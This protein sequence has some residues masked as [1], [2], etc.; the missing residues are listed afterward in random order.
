[1][2]PHEVLQPEAVADQTIPSTDRVSASAGEAVRSPLEARRGL[3]SSLGWSMP[4]VLGGVSLVLHQVRNP[5]PWVLSWPGLIVVALAVTTAFTDSLWRKI[6]NWLTYPAILAGLMIGVLVSCLGSQ[7][8]LGG[9]N[10]SGSLTGFVVCFLCMLFPYQASGGGAGDVKLAATY[11][12]LLGWQVGLSV[13][14]WSYMMAGLGL[15]VAQLMT[16]QPWLLP[17]ALMR[18]VGST[19]MPQAVAAPSENQKK[20]LSRPIPLAG[21]FAAGVTCVLCGGNLFGA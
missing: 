19:W 17:K 2:S 8:L 13:I 6:P 12:A 5:V 21:A 20:I 9:V 7:S 14:V 1:M 10:F 18:W 11:G 16:D 3:W 4:L 15:L